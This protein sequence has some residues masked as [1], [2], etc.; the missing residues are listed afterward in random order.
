MFLIWNFLTKFATAV[1]QEKLSI[2]GQKKH[3][4]FY[5]IFHYSPW[6]S[7]IFTVFKNRSSKKMSAVR[8]WRFTFS[9]MQ[10][11]KFFFAPFGGQKKPALRA[12][13]GASRRAEAAA[14]L[15]AAALP[16]YKSQEKNL[17]SG[18]E[19]QEKVRNFDIQ[20]RVR[21]LNLI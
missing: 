15:R 9:K 13:G 3:T 17:K 10:N 14:R 20:F 8:P 12:G 21:T 7:V 5:A 6:K 1:F 19:S 16:L 18:Q 4:Y 11:Q 2:F